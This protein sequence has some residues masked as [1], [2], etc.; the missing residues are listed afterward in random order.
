MRSRMFGDQRWEG[1]ASLAAAGF[2]A[3][4]GQLKV[5]GR[6]SLPIA[7]PNPPLKRQHLAYSRLNAAAIRST[8]RWMFSSE[9]A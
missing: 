8:A 3:G 1:G 4:P 6:R 9:L 5:A 2:N 7:L